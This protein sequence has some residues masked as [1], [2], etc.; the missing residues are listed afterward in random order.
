MTAIQ[1]VTAICGD[2]RGLFYPYAH[3]EIF[4]LHILYITQP[5]HTR[6]GSDPPEV[7]ASPRKSRYATEPQ[8]VKVRGLVDF[9]PR[10][11]PAS[12]RRL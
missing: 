7:P 10:R 4:T 8:R 3:T 11:V 5:A 9:S 2:L 6:I 12:P 1:I